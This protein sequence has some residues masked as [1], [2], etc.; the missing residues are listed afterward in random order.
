MM[1]NLQW[2]P[3]NH[4]IFKVGKDHKDYLLPPSTHHPCP[5]NHV[6]QCQVL[7]APCQPRSLQD[8]LRDME[9][10]H[11]FWSDIFLLTF[12]TQILGP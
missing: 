11:G 9:L 3:Q 1:Y 10:S 4:R 5:L 6:P 7:G 2:N 12:I 8:C